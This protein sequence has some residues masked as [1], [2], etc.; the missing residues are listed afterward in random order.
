[1]YDGAEGDSD[2]FEEPAVQSPIRMRRGAKT[3]NRIEEDDEDAPVEAY[4]PARRS[5]KLKKKS[6]VSPNLERHGSYGCSGW[7]C[8]FNCFLIDESARRQALARKG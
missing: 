4:R 2:Q 5:A 6:R 1:M 7:S 3:T 8:G